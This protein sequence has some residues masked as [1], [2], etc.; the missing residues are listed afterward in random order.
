[1]ASVPSLPRS[2]KRFLMRMLRS[3]TSRSMGISTLSDVVRVIICFSAD[4]DAM[5]ALLLKNR[6]VWKR[7]WGK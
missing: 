2:S 7:R 1:M 6:K 5:I 4:E 3:A